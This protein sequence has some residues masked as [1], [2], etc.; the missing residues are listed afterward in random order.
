MNNLIIRLE[1]VKDFIEVTKVTCAAFYGEERVTEI[2]VGCAE[3]H[4][5]HMLR[6]RD[7]MAT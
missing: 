4:M 6:Q 7:G 3:P 1:E 2:G 5:V